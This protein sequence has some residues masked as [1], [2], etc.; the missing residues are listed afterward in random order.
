MRKLGQRGVE[1]EYPGTV[2]SMGARNSYPNGNDSNKALKYVDRRM[3][4]EVAEEE[5]V[6]LRVL[7]LRRH[8]KDLIIS[9]TN[10][11]HIER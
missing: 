3:L 5:G 1:L 10:H 2:V 7:Y 9:V 6:D 4:S 11:R 8:V